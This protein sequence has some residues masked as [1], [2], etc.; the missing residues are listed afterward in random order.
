MEK[1][2]KYNLENSCAKNL[3]INLISIKNEIFEFTENV[4]TSE[5]FEI[6]RYYKLKREKLFNYISSIEF[7][8]RILNDENV[9]KDVL[10]IA[11]L[12]QT[13][14]YDYEELVHFIQIE[15]RGQR[16]DKACL[17]I[18]ERNNENSD[19]ISNIIDK[20]LFSKIRSYLAP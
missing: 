17:D 13:V 11:K 15:N 2:E 14:V 12:V 19:Q 6:V 18:I 4:I 7:E 1:K 5:N 8:A 3:A 10:T 16:M 9:L 20:S